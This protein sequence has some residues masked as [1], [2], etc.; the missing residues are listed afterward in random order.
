MSQEKDVS[1][2]AGEHTLAEQKLGSHHDAHL[3]PL[4]DVPYQVSTSYTLQ[5][6]RYILE[7]ILQ[8]KVTTARSKVKSRSHHDVAH[9]Q[10]LNNVPTMYQLPTPY[11]WRDI[12]PDKIL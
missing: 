4:T 9:L 3:H 6:Q 11:G 7:K 12:A 5:F 2:M 1:N 10:P 8:V